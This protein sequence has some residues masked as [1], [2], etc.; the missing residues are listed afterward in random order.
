MNIMKSISIWTWIILISAALAGVIAFA[1]NETPMRVAVVLWFLLVC[2]GMM[3]VRLFR[4]GDPLLEWIVAITLSLAADTFVGG[5]L[6]YSSKWSP[7]GAFVILLAL[8][9]GGVLAQEL[10]ALRAQRRGAA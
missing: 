3:L 7:S 10:Y 9:V 8:T 2:P 1:A 5:V 4:L 6:L